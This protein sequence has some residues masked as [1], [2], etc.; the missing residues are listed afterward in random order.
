[1]KLAFSSSSA[2]TRSAQLM[3]VSSDGASTMATSSWSAQTCVESG[4]EAMVDGVI[5]TVGK[6]HTG[7]T[8]GAV[9]TMKVRLNGD[10]WLDGVNICGG[11]GRQDGTGCRSIV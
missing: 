1:M 10:D 11:D 5:A 9:S 7:G 4:A 2:A 3:G 8:T 6:G